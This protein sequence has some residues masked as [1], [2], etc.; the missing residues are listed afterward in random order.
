MSFD[1]E[2]FP[3]SVYAV[4]LILTCLTLLPYWRNFPLRRFGQR[5][6]QTNLDGLLT[7]VRE[8]IILRRNR[9]QAQTSRLFIPTTRNQTIISANANDMELIEL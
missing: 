1:F 2:E 8:I 6:L 4:A 5:Y 7:W 3:V 9:Q